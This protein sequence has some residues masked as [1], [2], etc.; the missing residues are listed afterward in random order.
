MPG[1]VSHAAFSGVWDTVKAFGIF[2][3]RSFPHIRHNESSRYRPPR[4]VARRAAALVHVHEVGAA[5][6]DSLRPARLRGQDLQEVWFA[7]VHSDVGGGYPE[8]E[9]GLSWHAF[10]W[11]LG[12]ARLAGMKLGRRRNR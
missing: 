6:M 2:N 1:S 8:E 4:A 7:G 12:E 5:L 10:R 3:P 11:M 9:S